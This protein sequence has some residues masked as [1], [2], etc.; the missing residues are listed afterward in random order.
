MILTSTTLEDSHWRKLFY[1]CVDSLVLGEEGEKL[2]KIEEEMFVTFI[3]QEVEEEIRG[4]WT[5]SK[6]QNRLADFKIALCV[7]SSF[8]VYEKTRQLF[9]KSYFNFVQVKNPEK[10]FEKS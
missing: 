6:E 7:K 10:S 5:G 4:P 1:R 2:R 8:K 3:K 9:E